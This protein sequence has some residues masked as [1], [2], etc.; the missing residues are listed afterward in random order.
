M[1]AGQIRYREKGPISR[2]SEIMSVTLFGE[3]A[4]FAGAREAVPRK[5]RSSRTSERPKFL[6]RVVARVR[7]LSPG[8]WRGRAGKTFHEVVGAISEYSEKDIR[9]RERLQ[10]ALTCCGILRR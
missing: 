3:K 10:E 6:A 2:V 4:H 7:A 5:F 1:I 8:Q 9:I